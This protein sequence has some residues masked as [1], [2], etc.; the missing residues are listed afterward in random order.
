MRGMR[1]LSQKSGL[2]IAGLGVGRGIAE[3][4][5]AEVAERAQKSQKDILQ[6]LD[7]SASSGS[8]KVPMQTH[9]QLWDAALARI[10]GVPCVTPAY[11]CCDLEQPAG[12]RRL[13]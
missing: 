13:G 10:A 11:E 9:G 5:N 6:G 2:G 12:V 4:L 1:Q 8:K 7:F 3:I